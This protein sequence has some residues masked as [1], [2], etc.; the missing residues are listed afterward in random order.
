MTRLKM[1]SQGA[2]RVQFGV[3]WK[4]RQ[5]RWCS[6]TFGDIHARDLKVEQIVAM[7]CTDV[8]LWMRDVT[9]T[10]S[11]WQRTPGPQSQVV[12]PADGEL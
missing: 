7:G 4:N 9:T 2:I 10:Y 3:E 5:R 8:S 12:E 11:R 1:Q 6:D